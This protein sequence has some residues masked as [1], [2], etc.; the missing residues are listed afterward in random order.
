VEQHAPVKTA[1]DKGCGAYAVALLLRRHSDVQ[2][3]FEE[4][5]QKVDPD[6][7]GECSLLDLQRG[8]RGFGVETVAAKGPTNRSPAVASIIRLRPNA[9]KGRG[10]HFVLVEPAER[11][12]VWVF[13][14]PDGVALWDEATLQ[15]QWDGYLVY[16]SA[17]ASVVVDTM[18]LV[19]AV[20]IGGGALLM[21][22]RVAQTRLRG[23][24][25]RA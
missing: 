16:P 12:S 15:S 24:A 18:L 22:S 25:Q 4:V 5:S 1:L 21:L 9:G 11:G 13:D 20:G 14:P 17:G 23:K 2:A 10:E 3:T 19:L 8:L 6:G 7:D